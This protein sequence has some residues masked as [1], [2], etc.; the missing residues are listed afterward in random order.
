MPFLLLI[1]IALPSASDSGVMVWPLSCTRRS[2]GGEDDDRV[3]GAQAYSV[4]SAWKELSADKCAK[5]STF[6][7]STKRRNRF[8]EEGA[9]SRR[10][11][12]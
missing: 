1:P 6:R 8:Q 4:P 2:K 7:T 10:G 9:V 12:L 5:T 11:L 3:D